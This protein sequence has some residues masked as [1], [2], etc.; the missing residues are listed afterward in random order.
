MIVDFKYFS[1]DLDLFPFF[2]L[3]VNF[4]KFVLFAMFNVKIVHSR[5]HGMI[6]AAGF[7]LLGMGNTTDC[8]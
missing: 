8:K 6:L 4:V 5:K 7:I 3:E 1:F 2:I